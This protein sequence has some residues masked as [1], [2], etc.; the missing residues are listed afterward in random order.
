M[1]K[2]KTAQVVSAIRPATS[3][4]SFSAS[5][6]LDFHSP[7][8]LSYARL[9]SHCLTGESDGM[10]SK[11]ATKQ[12]ITR[13]SATKRRKHNLSAKSLGLTPVAEY[14]TEPGKCHARGSCVNCHSF[15]H[16]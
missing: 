11:R 5:A 1:C 7:Q 14:G 10:E 9:N 16:T 15:R 8:P 2:T 13:I 12:T 6:F 3:R 4:I